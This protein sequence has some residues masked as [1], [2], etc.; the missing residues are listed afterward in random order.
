M[1][2]SHYLALSSLTLESSAAADQHAHKLTQLTASQ[3][4]VADIDSL[5]D[6]DS[7]YRFQVPELGEGGTCSLFGELAEEPYDLSLILGGK[8]D[9]NTQLLTDLNAAVQEITTQTGAD[10]LG[11]YSRRVN[12]DGEEVLAKMAYTGAASRAEFPLNPAFA[13]LS[14]NSTVGLTGTGRLI[15]SVTQYR[16]AGG[17]YY[18]CDPKVQ[19]ELCIP[20]YNEQDKVIGILDAEAFSEHFFDDDKLSAFIGLA[21][22][23]QQR[24]QQ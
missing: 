11:V 9:Q 3:T 24:L 16:T 14:N 13:A 15:Q 6:I 23:T 5:T 4:A 1:L 18:T 2:A 20:L 10:W 8:S 22:W 7:L 12:R 17:E 21:L 19:A